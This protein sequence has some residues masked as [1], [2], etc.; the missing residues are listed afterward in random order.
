MNG[1]RIYLDHSPQWWIEHF[2]LTVLVLVGFAVLYRLL[3]RTFFVM[4]SLVHAHRPVSTRYQK[5]LLNVLRW[6][7]W[8]VGCIL[9]LHVWG[10]NVNALWTTL[11]SVLALIGVGLLAVWTMVSNI[12]ARFFIWFWRPLRLG[13]RVEV[14]PE[15]VQGIVVEENLMFTELRED[16]GNIIVIPNNLFFQRVIRRSSEKEAGPSAK[17]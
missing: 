15:A 7:F 3:S 16:D 2:L 4:A 10:V 12:T 6:L 9:I 5:I 14:F 8:V 11:V 1:Y 13:Q 17:K